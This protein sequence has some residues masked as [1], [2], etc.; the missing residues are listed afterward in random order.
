MAEVH[1]DK[2]N[3]D[4]EKFLVTYKLLTVEAK[5]AFEAQL[6]SS[7]KSM[8]ER[9]KKLYAVLLNSAKEGL[10]REQTIAKMKGAT[11]NGWS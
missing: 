7:I 5:A 10:D 4:V 3:R 8:D 11:D 2:L 6:E 1:F 9:N